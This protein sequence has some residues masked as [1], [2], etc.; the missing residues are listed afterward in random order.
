M[1]DVKWGAGAHGHT[2]P[3][4]QSVENEHICACTN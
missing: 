1:T 3:S 4:I 2:H